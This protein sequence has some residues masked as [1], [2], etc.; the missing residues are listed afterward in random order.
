[1]HNAVAYRVMCWSHSYDAFGN[2]AVHRRAVF[3]HG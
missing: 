2:A 3:R 1:M